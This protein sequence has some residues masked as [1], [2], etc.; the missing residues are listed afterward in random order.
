MT[1]NRH[2]SYLIY[3]NYHIELRFKSSGINRAFKID[4]DS[5]NCAIMPVK[6]EKEIRFA[7]D[8]NNNDNNDPRIVGR[9]L[10]G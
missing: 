8:N 5:K 6:M 2:K 4:S 9:S 10:A 7:N 1:Q 3:L